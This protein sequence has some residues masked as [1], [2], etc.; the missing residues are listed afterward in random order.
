MY[1]TKCKINNKV[2]YVPF[3]LFISV[4]VYVVAPTHAHAATCSVY[5]SR[6]AVPNGYGAAYNVFSSQR[7]TLLTADC[8][9]S[10]FSSSVGSSNTNSSNFA[11]YNLGYKWNGTQWTKNWYE[12]DTGAS[13]S[14]EYILGNAINRSDLAQVGE[15]TYF[16]AFMCNLVNGTWKCGCSDSP[17]RTPKWNLQVAVKPGTGGGSGG[18]SGSGGGTSPTWDPSDKNELNLPSCNTSGA[19][20]V[21][22]PGDLGK[23]SGAPSAPVV[24]VNG[25]FS[26]TKLTLSR[27]GKYRFNGTQVQFLEVLGN[28]IQIDGIKVDHKKAGGTSRIEGDNVIINDSLFQNGN[29]NPMVRITGNNFTLQNSVVRDT[30]PTVNKDR[31]CLLVPS[32][33]NGLRI[34]DNK[35]YDCAGDDIQFGPGARSNNVVIAGNDMYI[36]KLKRGNKACGA[37]NAMDFKGGNGVLVKNNKMH[38][39]RPTD[40]SCGGSGSKGHAV[41]VHREA[42]NITFDSNHSYDVFDCIVIKKKD[43]K[44]PLNVENINIMSN[45][46][47]DKI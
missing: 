45:N 14:G 44:W 20:T 23:L 46:R 47:C 11:V 4:F 43:D 29:Q 5:S 22:G 21:N 16:V 19:I 42:K 33:G 41:I 28:N 9:G 13:L 2:R 38:G 27:S 25:N 1:F 6:Y 10:T 8:N 24:C 26:S 40:S 31:H 12:P 15:N 7:E 30:V 3:L 35:M 36:D 32:G 18:G 17:C 34:I 39:F 37:E